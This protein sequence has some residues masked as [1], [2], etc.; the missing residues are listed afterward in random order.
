MNF[1]HRQ[2]FKYLLVVSFLFLTPKFSVESFHSFLSKI[3][4]SCLQEEGITSA[5]ELHKKSDP[6]AEPLLRTVLKEFCLDTRY[7]QWTHNCYSNTSP[8]LYK[9]I[10]KQMCACPM[11]HEQ[12]NEQHYLFIIKKLIRCIFYV[13]VKYI[14]FLSFFYRSFIAA[15][16]A[17]L[18]AELK[19]S[20]LTQL[21]KKRLTMCT[22]ELVRYTQK[23]TVSTALNTNN[24]NIFILKYLLNLLPTAKRPT[25]LLQTD[26]DMLKREIK[27]KEFFEVYQI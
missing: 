1:K 23:H 22:Q 7:G 9:D 8:Q 12:I 14:S 21:D 11:T 17:K 5:A 15:A 4:I 19:S 25:D 16:E 24:I 13:R 18:K 10:C 3:N 20:Y 2:K 27:R 26:C 6:E